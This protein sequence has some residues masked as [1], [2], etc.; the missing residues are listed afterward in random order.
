M[1]A[2]LSLLWEIKGYGKC[3]KQLVRW[4]WEIQGQKRYLKYRERTKALDN[5]HSSAGE[6]PSTIPT[7]GQA[8]IP[9]PFP[10][11]IP[12]PRDTKPFPT[13][14]K[15]HTGKE[16]VPLALEVELTHS[17]VSYRTTKPKLIQNSLYI[18][19]EG[20]DYKSNPHGKYISKEKPCIEIEQS[21]IKAF[22]LVKIRVIVVL[23]SYYQMDSRKQ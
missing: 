23:T 6:P 14:P 9:H 12:P 5:P 22:A 8:S 10:P 11:S 19:T 17:A 20:F 7:T 1:G 4:V 18:F 13:H 3:G 2:R 16:V 21:H 15:P